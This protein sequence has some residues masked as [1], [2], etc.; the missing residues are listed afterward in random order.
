[1]STMPSCWKKAMTIED[2]MSHTK[3]IQVILHYSISCLA[4]GKVFESLHSKINITVFLVITMSADGQILLCFGTSATR[5]LNHSVLHV[6]VTY[7]CGIGTYITLVTR[8]RTSLNQWQHS[9]QIKVVLTMIKSLATASNRCTDTCPDSKVHMAHMGPTWVVSAPGGPHVGTM[10][11][12]IRVALHAET[13]LTTA[14]FEKLAVVT[15]AATKRY[16]CVWIQMKL[17]VCMYYWCVC[18]YIS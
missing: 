2:T 11:L 4:N 13:Y 8:C 3:T 12:A 14:S 6:S 7:T 16:I 15:L 18:M 17:L 1:M 9:F 5:V 10:N